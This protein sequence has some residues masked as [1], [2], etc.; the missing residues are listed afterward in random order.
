MSWHPKLIALARTSSDLRDRNDIHSRQQRKPG[1]NA[2]DAR[3]RA[4]SAELA[5][6]L[7]TPPKEQKCD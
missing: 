2:R 1:E 7:A 6:L 5:D 3:Q 4:A